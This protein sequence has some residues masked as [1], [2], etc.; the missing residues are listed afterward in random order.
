MVDLL[1]MELT[2]LTPLVVAGDFNAWAVEWGSRST[3]QRG[4]ILLEALAKLNLDL[5]NV[6][7]E[8]SYSRNGAESIIDVTFS[9]PGL[10]MN[11]RVDD[12]Y[13]N[14][15]HQTVCYSVDN[16][17]RRQATSRANTPF[18]RGWKTSHFDAEVFEE[19]M[20]REREGG[21]RLRPTPNQLIAMLSRACDATMPRTRQ[22]RNGGVTRP[23]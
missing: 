21:S 11:W 22:P 1:F 15:D 5:A 16:N 12:G 17:E 3:N 19:A 7:S 2:G 4:Q 18:A 6:G 20:R 9:S 13:T 8:S 14:S 23:R 10:I